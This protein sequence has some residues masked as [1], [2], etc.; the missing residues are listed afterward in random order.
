M[1]SLFLFKMLIAL[2][3]LFISCNDELKDTII[4][5]QLDINIDGTE[6]Q[7]INED[8]GGNE[9][10]DKLYITAFYSDKDKIDFRIRFEISKEGNLLNV[11]YAEP[12]NNL[13]KTFITP[14]FNPLS[15]FSI[16]NFY[17]DFTT[18]EVRFDFD[19][20]LY[21]EYDSD[22]SMAIF[23][24]IK[25]K[26]LKSIECS[27]YKKGLSYTSNQLNLFSFYTSATKY[28]DKT[29]I[30]RFLS[31]N[32]FRIY[33]HLSK[34][35]WLYPLGEINFDENAQID[36][37]EFKEIIGIVV[38]DQVG[39]VKETQWKNFETSGAIIIE[40]KYTEKGKKMIRG[41]INLLVKDNGQVIYN[42]NGIDFKTNSFE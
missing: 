37:V 4:E 39:L 26:S 30:H 24:K 9:N 6:Y 40:A 10:C 29:Q 7:S 1:K 32:G 13:F 19:G 17:Y 22:N 16:S 33:L 15:T 34:D 20:T 25:I 18:G 5:N 28:E 35:L 38:T 31:N 41:K 2:S 23:G 21:H 42:L 8:I 14:N 36:K 27:T 12:K 11:W 3:F